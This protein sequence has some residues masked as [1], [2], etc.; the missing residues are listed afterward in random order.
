MCCGCSVVSK[1]YYYV[2]DVSHQVIKKRPGHSDFKYI[3]SKIKITGKA[4]DSIGSATISNGFGHPLLM[5]PL[6]FPVIP[7]G[8]I[9]HKITSRFVMELTVDCN[10]GYFM[11]MAIDSIGYKRTRDSLDAAAV[12]TTAL[13]TSNTSY[14][15]VN[16]TLKVPL[17]VR[18]Y[19]TGNKKGHAYRMESGIKFRKVKT[20]RLVTGN[21][22][23]DSTFNKITFTRKSRIK[24]DL[25][26]PVGY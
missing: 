10:D 12:S 22:I 14:M 7:V 18:E 19:F 4:G 3:Y 2:P 24:Y 15:V 13:L 5:G 21:A 1:Q 26:G 23:L 6:V 8:G 9:A 11:P 16:D 20:M 17:Q 25:A